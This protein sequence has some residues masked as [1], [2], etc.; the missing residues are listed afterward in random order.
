MLRL[1]ARGPAAFEPGEHRRD[2][3]GQAPRRALGVPPEHGV[4][5]RAGLF[6]SL[7]QA[8]L[9]LSFESSRLPV[10]RSTPSTAT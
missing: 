3:R 10:A 9:E 8:P 2:L 5:E 4:P 6:A 7:E 1:M